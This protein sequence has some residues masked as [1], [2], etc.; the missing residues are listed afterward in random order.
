[1]DAAIINTQFEYDRWANAR[2]LGVVAGLSPEAL[3]KDLGS[4]FGSIRNTVVHI[5]SGEWAWLE[6]WNGTS[7]KAMWDPLGFPTVEAL[8]PRWAEVERD[9]LAFL[10]ALT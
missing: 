2:M 9:Q 10:R 7:P 5:I 8:R 1:M 6:R 3:L 4:S